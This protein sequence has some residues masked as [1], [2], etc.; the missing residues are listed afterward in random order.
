V[1]RV[2]FRITS[3]ALGLPGLDDGEDSGREPEADFI[4][5]ATNLIRDHK[6]LAVSGGTSIMPGSG[7]IPCPT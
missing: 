4:N 1:L 6:D 7:A 5:P 3:L 2:P